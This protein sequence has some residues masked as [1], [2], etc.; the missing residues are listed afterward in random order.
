MNPHEAS[1]TA[2]Y[3]A[4]FRALETVR[5][6][7]KARLFEDPFAAAFLGPEILR[8]VRLA[9]MPILGGL[10]RSHVEWKSAGA[11][12]SGIARTRLIDDWLREALHEGLRR[13]VL[14]G[15]GYDCRAQ[16]LPEL[17]DRRVVEIDHPAT[18]AAKK[19]RLQAI[20]G[21]L[22]GNVTYL[23][24]DLTK[25]N[26][27]DVWNHDGAQLNSA[28]HV[29]NGWSTVQPCSIAGPSGD[30]PVFVLW[31]GV[32][33]Y[34]GEAAVDATLR[35]LSRLCPPGSRLAF[36]YLHR[37][38]LDGSLSFKRAQVARD[39]V[40]QGGEPW[41][42]GMDP[43]RLPEYLAERGFQLRKDLGAD[44]YRALYWDAAARRLQGFGFYHVAMAGVKEVQRRV[45]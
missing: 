43:A 45:A 9:A 25:Q 36:T 29:S 17:A 31:E 21:A 27:E 8:Y 23:P 20:L 1:R 37:G 22:P 35:A 18:Q 14:L 32:T 39:R 26:L 5:R 40:A 6:P 34:L 12:S 41:I 19:E 10:V 7:A 28:S 11:M 42:W 3:A 30:E 13:V 2:E 24:A 4:A 15:A 44:E 33:H 38:L 16:R